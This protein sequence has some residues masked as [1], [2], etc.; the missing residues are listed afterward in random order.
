ML[1]QRFIFSSC[2][3]ISNHGILQLHQV[4]LRYEAI[5]CI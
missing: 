3:M 4:G 5:G 1:N 2:R